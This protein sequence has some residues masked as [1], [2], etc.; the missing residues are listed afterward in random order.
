ML[1]EKHKQLYD[2]NQIK[3]YNSSILDF[4]KK[5]KEQCFVVGMEILDNMPHD[6][7]YR[8]ESGEFTTQAMVNIHTDLKSGEETLEEVREPIDDQ[9]V[10]DFL[11]HLE[12]MPQVDH[13]SATQRLQVSG[14]IKRIKDVY[15]DYWHRDKINNNIYA[16]TAALYL[17]QH[18][19]KYVPNHSLILADFDCF[20]ERVQDNKL[21]GL[22]SPLVTNKLKEPTEWT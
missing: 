17:F 19:H 6:R 11:R 12:S 5:I 22:N 4:N 1:S 7:L 2:R 8:D 15:D 21:I 18:L 9:L 16:P 13:I 20:L 10:K 3:I 14:I